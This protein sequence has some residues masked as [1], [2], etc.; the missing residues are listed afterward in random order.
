MC[1][2]E[3]S[4]IHVLTIIAFYWVAYELYQSF[5]FIKLSTIFVMMHY[6]VIFWHSFTD[7]CHLLY[8]S[9]DF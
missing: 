6:F 5:C 3:Q 2:W 9:F 1:F 4:H 8:Y 7:I